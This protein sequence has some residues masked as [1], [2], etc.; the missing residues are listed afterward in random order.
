MKT[1]AVLAAALSLSLVSVAARAQVPG[2]TVRIETAKGPV[3]GTLVD[4]L[5]AGYLVNKGKTSVVV[6]YLSVTGI[7]KLAPAPLAPMSLPPG[8]ATPPAQGKNAPKPQPAAAAADGFRGFAVDPAPAEGGAPVG[9][10]PPPP[11]PVPVPAAPP[12]PILSPVMVPVPALPAP[13][14]PAVPPVKYEVRSKIVMGT[15]IAFVALGAIAA[16]TGMGLAIE[17]GSQPD[18]VCEK[19]ASGERCYTNPNKQTHID[20]GRVTM[21]AGSVVH[22]LGYPIWSIGGKKVPV[23]GP[24]PSAELDRGSGSG[25][26]HAALLGR[27]W[28][29]ARTIGCSTAGRCRRGCGRWRRAEASGRPRA[30]AASALR[31]S[32]TRRRGRRSTRGRRS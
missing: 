29:E 4:R 28:P 17:G 27:C 14:R 19:Y 12:P 5:P 21:L 10:E 23:K 1:M 18:Q 26:A 8:T 16:I 3:E 31:P 20:A 2:D 13:P 6:P 11:P 32:G 9:V 25:R 7:T 30:T 24:A 15:G 22:V